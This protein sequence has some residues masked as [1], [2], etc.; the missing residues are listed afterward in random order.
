M[1]HPLSLYRRAGDPFDESPGRFL[2]GRIS[3]DA[4][5]PTAETIAGLDARRHRSQCQSHLAHHL[6]D[7]RILVSGAGDAPSLHLCHPARPK[8]GLPLIP[9]VT[10]SSGRS[11]GKEGFEETQRPDICGCV[12]SNIP[13]RIQHAASALLLEDHVILSNSRSL[14]P[15]QSDAIKPVL[16]AVETPGSFQKL[17]VGAGGLQARLGKH[18]LAVIQHIG[19]ASQ[20]IGPMPALPFSQ[21]P[22]HGHDVIGVQLCRIPGH[23]FIQGQGVVILCVLARPHDVHR[24]QIVV[25]GM[26]H[27]IRSQLLVEVH[28]AQHIQGDVSAGLLLELGNEIAKGIHV[29]IAHRGQRQ[30]HAFVGSGI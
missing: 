17:L 28:I 26:S 8:R 23:E 16:G 20:G 10:G 19:I 11:V 6:R 2:V 27:E 25:G 30:F 21:R 13:V 4:D 18:I 7:V 24:H 22:G 29:L 1:Q 15:Q 5:A 3:V 14:G 9:P 12:Q